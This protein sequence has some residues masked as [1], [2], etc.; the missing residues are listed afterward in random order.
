MFVGRAKELNEL[1]W[2]YRTDKFQLAV[3]YGRR[4]VGKT[5]LIN[6]FLR[7]KE[8]IFFTAQET[9][10]GQNLENFSRDVFR[11]VYGHGPAPTFRSFLDA[12]EHVFALS[13]D[14][15][16]VLVIDEYQRLERSHEGFAS[17]LQIM[18]DRHKDVSRLFLVLCG[19]DVPLMGGRL[20]GGGG[21]LQGRQTA[22]L[23]VEPFDFFDSRRFFRGFSDEDTALVYG[24]VGGMPQ[25]LLQMHDFISVEDNIKNAFLRPSSPFSEEPENLLRQG[26][27]ELAIYNAV[28]TAVA[29]GG[30]RVSEVSEKT[31]EGTSVCSAYLKALV[32]MGVLKKETPF[33][34]KT[35][36]RTTYS[37]ADNMLRFWYRFIPPN[38]SAIQSGMA[39]AVYGSIS[40]QLPAFMGGV[41]EDICRQYLWRLRPGGGAPVEFTGMGRWWGVDPRTKSGAE[42]GIIAADG[43]GAALFC[44]CWWADGEVDTPALDGLVKRSELFPFERRRFCLFAKKGFTPGCVERAAELGGAGLITFSDMLRRF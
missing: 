44:D 42:I 23:R 9:N 33:A 22:Q 40:K 43:A 35:Q 27:R 8:A 13:K 20:T 18:I 38:L 1:N 2:L 12:L 11:C 28:I 32:G 36:K 17:L 5:A 3:V 34:E 6:E 29:G 30:A 37:V 15:R 31:G 7:G 41:F 25:Y 26:V 39:D 21:P 10:A 16:L 14:R 4:R 19:S 24:V